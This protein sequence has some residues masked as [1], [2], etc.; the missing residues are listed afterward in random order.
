MSR[1]TIIAAAAIMAGLLS[2]PASAQTQSKYYMRSKIAPTGQPNVPK[3]VTC[4]T[5]K[6]SVWLQQNTAKP[7]I[8]VIAMTSGHSTAVEAQNWCNQQPGLTD[9]HMCLFQAQ[10]ATYLVVNALPINSISTAYAAVCS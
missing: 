10:G 8:A 3:K 2:G 5:P 1:T 7:G 4:Q 9:N 6:A